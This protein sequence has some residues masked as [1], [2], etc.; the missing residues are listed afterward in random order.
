M[1][2]QIELKLSTA[3]LN[4][5]T[6]QVLTTPTSNELCYNTADLSTILEGTV[7]MGKPIK[8]IDLFAGVGGF[9]LGLES[10]KDKAGSKYE[11]VWSN[12]WEP[13]TKEQ[14]AFEI[15][16]SKFKTGIHSNEDISKVNVKTIPEYDMLVGGFPCQDYSVARTLN[17]AAGIVGKKGVLWW[18]IHRLIKDGKRPTYLMLENVDR[19]LKSPASQRGRDFAIMLAS[20]SD[21]GYAVEWR[22]INAADYGFPQRRKR[23]YFVGYHKNSRIYY[24]LAERSGRKDWLLANG[25]MAKAFNVAP[26][27][28]EWSNFE[29]KGELTDLTQHFGKGNEQTGFLNSGLIIDREVL[30]MRT[31]PV[32]KGKR[33]LLGDIVQKKG[34]PEEYYLNNQELPKWKFLKGAKSIKRVSRA[35]GHE[36][37]YDEGSMTFPD[38]LDQPSRTIVTGEG[39]ATPSRFKHVIQE[40]P[41][42]FRRLMPIELERL[43]GFPPDHTRL[44]G[45]SPIRRAFLMGNA[46]VVGVIERLGRSLVEHIQR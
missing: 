10:V 36:Y 7:L 22:V 33:Q 44:N 1:T 5:G 34:V 26:E 18:Q 40:G 42:R 21:L 20:L 39:G 32:Y 9:R 8:V 6:S 3:V 14:H 31:E 37:T 2:E 30:T 35:T 23:I 11:V 43:N 28:A 24:E 45:M 27:V 4:Q 41:D 38:K 19:L 16:R 17:Q 29:L 15:Y 12:Q 13:A 46:L 25:V